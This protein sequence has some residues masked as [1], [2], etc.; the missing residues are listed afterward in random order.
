MFITPATAKEW[1][2][3]NLSGRRFGDR[4]QN[5]KFLEL[6]VQQF[7]FKDLAYLKEVIGQMGKDICKEMF[8]APLFIIVKDWKRSKCP[9]IEDSLHQSWHTKWCDYYATVAKDQIELYVRK[10]LLRYLDIPCRMLPWLTF[11]Q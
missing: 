6:S 7:H 2:W 5:F 1:N 4:Y 8:N 3:Y 11:S 9:S 10:T